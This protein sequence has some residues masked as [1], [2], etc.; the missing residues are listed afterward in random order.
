MIE[1]DIPSIDPMQHEPKIFF[2]LTSRQC[3]CIVP[4]AII[5]V[6]LFM[7]TY[8]LSL[9]VAVVSLCVGV[10][11]AV[12]MGWLTPYNMKFEQYLKLLW[13]NS[14]VSNPKRIYKT[15]SAEE[16]KRL[17]IKELQDLENKQKAK[18]MENKKK[19]KEKKKS[20]AK[21]GL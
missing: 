6:G 17:T 12:C 9:D 2:G 13:F 20:S 19:N 14:F 5:G 10:A 8:N 3:L 1:I 18:E 7:L 11:P 4:G 15:D 16:V 21:E